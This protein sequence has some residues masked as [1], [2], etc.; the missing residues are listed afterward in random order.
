MR[1]DPSGWGL[2]IKAQTRTILS[3]V[4]ELIGNL[5]VL[6]GA[7]TDTTSVASWAQGMEQPRKE[8][9][10][11]VLRVPG[12][13]HGLTR[14]HVDAPLRIGALDRGQWVGKGR[15]DG[16]KTLERHIIYLLVTC[17]LS[18]GYTFSRKQNHFFESWLTH[19]PLL[20]AGFVVT[21]SVSNQVVYFKWESGYVC[22]IST[23]WICVHHFDKVDTC[24]SFQ[25]RGAL[26]VPLLAFPG[27][28][29]V[30]KAGTCSRHRMRTYV[31]SNRWLGQAHQDRPPCPSG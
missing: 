9:G 22:I 7:G 11:C 20:W 17:L 29:F 4:Q 28:W 23:K 15:Y 19:L 12:V 13:F 30:V 5:T 3:G 10:R 26:V 2:P 14:K 27:D 6:F 18:E 25:Q 21:L 16:E 1:M 31:E 24:A 8:D